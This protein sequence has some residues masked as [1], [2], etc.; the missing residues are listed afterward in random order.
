MRKDPGQITNLAKDPDKR[1]IR[2][3]LSAQLTARLADVTSN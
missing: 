2:E 1:A 3:Q